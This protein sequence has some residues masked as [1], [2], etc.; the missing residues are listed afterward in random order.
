MMEI[1]SMFSAKLSTTEELVFIFDDVLEGVIPWRTFLEHFPSVK[2]FQMQ[3]TNN[4]RVA[5][6]LQPYH[7][8]SGLS[9]LPVLERITFRISYI[10]DRLSELAVFQP[11]VSA[12]QQAGRPV[13]VTCFRDPLIIRSRA[14]LPRSESA[15][16]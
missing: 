1:T 6:A 5:S 10:A 14:T 16:H 13:Q 8:G 2:E 9:I 15:W 12:R 3:G 7:G 11:F 4:H